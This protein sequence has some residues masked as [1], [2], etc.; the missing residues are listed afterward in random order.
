[1]K[2]LVSVGG[3]ANTFNPE[4]LDSGQI[5]ELASNVVNFIHSNGL[6]GID[7]D[8]EVKTDPNLIM[9]LL[10]DVKYND[11]NILLTAAPQI[12]NGHSVTTGDN[13]DYQ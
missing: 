13:Q 11:E 4:T 10:R 1:M 3:Q 6:D 9:Y 8:I 7:F 2:V 12:N 5:S